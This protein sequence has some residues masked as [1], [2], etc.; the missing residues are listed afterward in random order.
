MIRE[1]PGRSPALSRIFLL[2]NCRAGPR[3]LCGVILSRVLSDQSPA[4]P[5]C[6]MI[7]ICRAGSP[8]FR[9]SPECVVRLR[10]PD[11]D[12]M[13]CLIQCPSRGAPALNCYL[14]TGKL[15]RTGCG[16]P[17][18]ARW[19]VCGRLARGISAETAPEGFCS[20]PPGQ[21]AGVWLGESAAE[22]LRGDSAAGP[23]CL[24]P[25]GPV[26]WVGER[27]L[28]LPLLPCSSVT[29]RSGVSQ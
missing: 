22:T 11:S 6:P 14:G 21:P 17:A 5:R 23:Q 28:L 24:V 27:G 3:P 8:T 18:A 19:A 15:G 7:A 2:V 12:S 29:S 9:W 13:Y 16:R 1:V 20:C 4:L 25:V 26:H 10:T